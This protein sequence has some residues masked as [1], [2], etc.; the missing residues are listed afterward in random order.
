MREIR[1]R[2]PT[3]K[4]TSTSRFATWVRRRRRST[5]TPEEGESEKRGAIN[6]STKYAYVQLPQPFEYECVTTFIYSNGLPCGIESRAAGRSVELKIAHLLVRSFVRSLHISSVS[7]WLRHSP[8]GR[9]RGDL[10]RRRRDQLGE[11]LGWRRRRALRAW[12]GPTSIAI[13]DIQIYKES[14]LS[15][16]KLRITLQS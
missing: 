15:M 2:N 16:L 3:T 4:A 14:Q 8:D 6:W 12:E 5:A 10:R 11:V 9:R 1:N 13:D 7:V